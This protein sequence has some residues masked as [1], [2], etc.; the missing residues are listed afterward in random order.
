MA[1]LE[2][3]CFCGAVRY[4]VA[5]DFGVTHCHCLHCR[6]ISG[7]PFVT[8][9]EALCSNFA[10]LQGQ[11]SEFAA[12]PGVTRTYCAGCGTPLTYQNHGHPD[13][14]DITAGSLDDASGLNPDDHVWF[15]RKL[16]WIRIDDGLPRYGLGRSVK[17]D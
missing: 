4:R 3:G 15:D 12:R 17:E 11:P 6:K 10:W 14:I 5:G 8:W 13:S 7:A 16:P 2:G 1:V 9:V